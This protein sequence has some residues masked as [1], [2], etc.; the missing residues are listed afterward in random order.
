MNEEESHGSQMSDEEM[1]RMIRQ[2]LP[3]KDM[4]T[5]LETRLLN[6][7]LNAA[8]EELGPDLASIDGE[9]LDLE[10][11][12]IMNREAKKLGVGDLIANF[13]TGIGNLFRG[14]RRDNT[15]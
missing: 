13:F 8:K 1:T 3:L 14:R 11:R 4:P 15:E 6:Q 9:Q 2:F 10:F 5:D 12:Q 7:V